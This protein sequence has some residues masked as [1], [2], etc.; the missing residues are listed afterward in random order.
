MDYTTHYFSPIGAIT[1]ASDGEALTGLWFDGQRHFASTLDSVHEERDDLPI[2]SESVRW[3]DIYFGGGEPGF[4]P[5]LLLRG[6]QFRRHVWEAL[7]AIPFGQTLTYG[8]LA[9]RIALQLGMRSLSPQAVGGAVGHNPI[10]LVV[11]CHRVVGSKGALTGYAG[12]LDKKRFLLE[13]EHTLSPTLF[14]VQ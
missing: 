9:R 12:G 11:P 6:S 1:L 13:M 10:S 7:L 14:G 5:A 3:L 4:T 2:F 8:E